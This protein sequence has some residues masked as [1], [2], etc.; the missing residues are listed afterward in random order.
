MSIENI[1]SKIIHDAQTEADA[2]LSAARKEAA[3]IV[4]DAEKKAAALKAD[5]EQRGR[6]EK[7]KL[8]A[9]R[10]SVADIDGRKILLEKKQQKLDACFA[11]AVEKVIGME[12]EAYLGFLV[13][14]IKDTGVSGGELIF[15]EAEAEQT[16]PALLEKLRHELPESRFSLSEE[17]RSIG[18]GFI[19]KEGAV[20]ING[21]IEA[22]VA[23]AREDLL[24]SVAALLFE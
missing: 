6:E 20:F 13:K 19:L 24:P 14:V 7:E 12:R 17:R 4:A 11:Q 9:R 22:L 1:I 5:A 2:T 3:E 15:N 23:E 21:T 16:G 8:T 10:K 18:G